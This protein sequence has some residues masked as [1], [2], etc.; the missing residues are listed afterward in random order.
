MIVEKD[1]SKR[2][3]VNSGKENKRKGFR[4]PKG[5]EKGRKTPNNCPDLMPRPT[6]KKPTRPW[7]GDM[8]DE[9]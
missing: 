2:N 8:D 9:R 6:E 5:V 4:L 7:N 1:I 3:T